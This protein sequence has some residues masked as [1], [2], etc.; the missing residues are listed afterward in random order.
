M[1]CFQVNVRKEPTEYGFMPTMQMYLLEGP[2]K[3]RP[4]VLIVPGGGYT[5]LCTEADGEKNAMQYNA[6]GFH[7]AV[8]S[9]SVEPH[10][11]PEPQRDLMW[12]IRILRENGDKW[13]IHEEQIAI[14]GFSAGG[15]LCARYP[16][17]PGE[18]GRGA[19]QAQCGD[20][21]LCHTD[22]PAEPLPEFPE[23][24]CEWG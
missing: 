17:V 9:Y 18:R 7:A 12:A 22:Y 5:E 8:L 19:V 2:E 3:K 1:R 15:H 4:V 16:V 21:V 24:P 6:A 20:S 13:G 23:R 14:I 10:F 11:F